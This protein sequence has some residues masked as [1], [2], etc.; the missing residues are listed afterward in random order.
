MTEAPA[1]LDQEEL[2]SEAIDM[3]RTVW[4]I[5]LSW[6]S[7]AK[8]KREDKRECWNATSGPKH[9]AEKRPTGSRMGKHKGFKQL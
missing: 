1:H 6:D 7:S 8:S 4:K 3:R 2:R 9:D 5:I